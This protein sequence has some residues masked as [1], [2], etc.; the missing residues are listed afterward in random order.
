MV[1][2]GEHRALARELAARGQLT[3]TVAG[4][5]MA[6]TLARGAQVTIGPAAGVLPGDVVLFETADRRD[7]VLHRVVLCAPGLSWFVH[8]G[9]APG[10]GGPARASKRQIIGRARVPRRWPRSTGLLRF[11]IGG[12]I[13]VLR[14]QKSRRW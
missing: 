1:P 3:I 9:D 13:K 12:A 8:A 10:G 6:P 4:D 5:S 14:A 11:S 7:L 2:A